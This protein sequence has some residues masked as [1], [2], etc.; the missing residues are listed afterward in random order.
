MNDYLKSVSS[1]ST[2]VTSTSLSPSTEDEGSV[3]ELPEQPPKATSS[4]V[5]EN[6][7]QP[8]SYGAQYLSPQK[9]KMRKYTL[10]KG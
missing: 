7:V 8:Q 9:V 5:I 10:K 1:I 6:E 2:S 3:L 4:S